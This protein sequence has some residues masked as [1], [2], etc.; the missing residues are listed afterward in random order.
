MNLRVC[1]P[2][3]FPQKKEDFIMK[4]RKNFGMFIVMLSAV[5]MFSACSEAK[6]ASAP[7]VHEQSAEVS[8]EEASEVRD[9]FTESKHEM[10][11]T[12]AAT[13]TQEEEPET[14][15]ETETEMNT[16]TETD[17]QSTEEPTKEDT[18]DEEKPK[19]IEATDEAFDY[20]AMGNSVTCNEISNLW[21]GNWGMA[22]S[23]ED[24]DY[25]H[26]VSTWL[27]GQSAKPVTTTVL[28]LKKWEVAQDRGSVLE[29]YEK[30]LNE[31]TDLITIQTGENIT[32][33]KETLESDYAD[34][35]SRI[36]QK[37][38]NAQ[39]L[40]LG[41]VLWPAEDIE[42]AKRLACSGEGITFIEMSDFLNGYEGLYKSAMG[43]SVATSDGSSFTISN[44]VVAA[45]P[46]DDGMACIAQL[47]INQI[48]IS[49][50]N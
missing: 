39:I 20:V 40:M 5:L 16:E 22:A 47:V 9:A 33:F 28:D 27:G 46:N 23:S 41:E 48:S 30:Y 31:Y 38:P 17:L 15:T 45:H 1:P 21:P 14:E 7:E 35:V 13:E 19:E 36:R 6:D 29:D 12:E 32:E 11:D 10:S 24:R 3:R 18:E 2:G 25:V 8:N 26:I 37:A 50:G 49:N 42:A 4:K 34:L 44:E 43:A